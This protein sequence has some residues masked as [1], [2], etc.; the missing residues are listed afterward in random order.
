MQLTP[1][2]YTKK[3]EKLNTK[4]EEFPIL[5][6]E[7]ASSKDFETFI[8]IE[9]SVGDSSTYSP[10][11]DKEEA[12]EEI[13]NNVVYFIRENEQIV[14]SV[15]YRM[16]TP[17]HAYIS[18]IAIHPDFQGRGIGKAAMEK[19]LEELSAVPTIDLVTHPDNARAIELYTSLGFALGERIENYFDDG[20]PRVVMTLNKG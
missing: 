6:F 13:E 8:E 3:M 18:G 11:I 15:M 9:R 20:E 14:G 5:S 10:T 7:R 12:L 17:D 19:V 1:E 2:W 4:R 16:K